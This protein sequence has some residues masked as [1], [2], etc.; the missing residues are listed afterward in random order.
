MNNYFILLR[1][2]QYLKNLFIFLP[3]FFGLKLLQAGLFIQVFLAFLAFSLV[4]SG[5]YI[6]NDY[7]DREEDRKHPTKKNRPL[8][9]GRVNPK[10]ALFIMVGLWLV[11]G[12]AAFL[13]NVAAFYFMAA[14][15]IL[16]IFYSIK[17]KHIPIVDVFVI[18]LGFVIRLFVGSV[19]ASIPLSVWIILVTFM[20]ALFLGFAKRRNDVLLFLENGSM[21]RKSVDGYSLEFLNI[22]L[23]ITAATTII[24]YIMYTVSPL[25][26]NRP[27]GEWL[28][29]TSFFV[30]AGVL[31]YVQLI[32]ASNKELLP[33][34]VLWEDRFIQ[35]TLVLWMLLFGV[36]LY[37]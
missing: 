1:P 27:G 16:N 20:L 21:A 34:M 18:A 19:T 36:I 7:L 2:R 32:F 13:I 5:V 9:S 22:T 12:G 33:T 6:L 10:T 30:I 17:L 15:V 37:T 3:L 26:I 25:V 11:G 28:Y 24:S 35:S 29:V 14:Y 8:A 31:R 4:A 23:G